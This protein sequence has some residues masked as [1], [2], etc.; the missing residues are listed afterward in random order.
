MSDFGRAA[1]VRNWRMRDMVAS[2]GRHDHLAVAANG[3]TEFPEERERAAQWKIFVSGTG[4]PSS[5]F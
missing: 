5:P 2:S 1:N 4:R 3:S